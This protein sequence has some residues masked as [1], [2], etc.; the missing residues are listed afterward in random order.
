MYAVFVKATLEE[1]WKNFSQYTPF[2]HN[3]INKTTLMEQCQIR[4]VVFLPIPWALVFY[5]I[6]DQPKL[7]E[8]EQKVP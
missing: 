7:A 3:K 4:Q 6:L 8:I 2:G 1:N 5:V